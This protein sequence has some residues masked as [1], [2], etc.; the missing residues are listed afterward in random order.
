MVRVRQIKSWTRDG[1]NCCVWKENTCG[2][3]GSIF[4]SDK[5][6]SSLVF[7]YLVS[8]S[9]SCRADVAHKIFS[10]S[11]SKTGSKRARVVQE[12]QGEHEQ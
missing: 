12:Q 3:N 9:G 2:S 1:G 4:I 6:L 8:V 7:L 11:K 10:I 5:K